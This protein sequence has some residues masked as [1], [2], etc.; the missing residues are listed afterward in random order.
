MS[1][2]PL[3][4]RAWSRPAAHP[5]SLPRSW[6]RTFPSGPAPCRHRAQKSTETM[7]RRCDGADFEAVFEVI[8]DAA[9]AYR[10]VIAD[11]CWAEPYMPRAELRADI[12]AGVVF[13]GFQEADALASVMGLQHVGEVALIRHAYTRTARQGAG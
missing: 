3:P 8:N 13:W 11:D 10:G 5:S 2:M 4:T 1:R 7:I 6:P 9:Q 12:E